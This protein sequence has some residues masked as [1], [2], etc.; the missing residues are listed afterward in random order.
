MRQHTWTRSER[1]VPHLHRALPTVESMKRDDASC[2]SDKEGKFTSRNRICQCGSNSSPNN[3]VR[4]KGIE[5][6]S[7]SCASD[8]RN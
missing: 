4:I 7:I 6:I 2:N 8:T 3:S 1:F 5:V